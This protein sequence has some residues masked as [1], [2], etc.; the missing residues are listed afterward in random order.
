MRM[1][2]IDGDAAHQ[3]QKRVQDRFA[4]KF[5]VDDVANWP[6][7]G[8]LQ[9]HRIHPSDM[10]RQEQESAF[11]QVVSSER[12]DS[13]KATHQ[14]PPEEIERAFCGGHGS[15]C[16]SFTINLWPSAI[17]NWRWEAA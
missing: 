15:H 12:S 6:G 2:R 1:P 7:P 14:Q 9:N 8:E 17:G 13:I 10:V 11:W 4:I 5:L 3:P 16:L